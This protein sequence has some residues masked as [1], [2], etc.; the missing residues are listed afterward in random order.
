MN[1]SIKDKAE[2]LV[3]FINEFARK[4]EM[5]AQQNY[6][7]LCDSCYNLLGKQDIEGLS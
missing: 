5:T 7:S 1:E 2:Y 4:Y 6:R 3:I